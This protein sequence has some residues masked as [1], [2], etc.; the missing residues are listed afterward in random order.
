M[1]LLKEKERKGTTLVSSFSSPDTGT[2]PHLPPLT[3]LIQI[4]DLGH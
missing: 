1:Y 3:E 2:T 4:G